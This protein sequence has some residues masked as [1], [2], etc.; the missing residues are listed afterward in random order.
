MELITIALKIRNSEKYVEGISQ[1]EWD[2]LKL[3][4]PPII[5]NL[6]KD[7][8]NLFPCSGSDPDGILYAVKQGYTIFE[9]TD[10][11][12]VA[13]RIIGQP[14]K[15]GK[16]SLEIADSGESVYIRNTFTNEYLYAYGRDVYLDSSP[17]GI[18]FQWTLK[19]FDSG[20]YIISLTNSNYL[21]AS[22]SENNNRFI[23]MQKDGE[24]DKWNTFQCSK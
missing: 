23:R 16:W 9:S 19:H 14:E 8:I 10:E 3:M 5:N 20:F 1:Q 18:A 24:E 15:G 17:E 6:T 22:H 13:V 11:V 12:R 4:L 2:D 7:E 21:Y